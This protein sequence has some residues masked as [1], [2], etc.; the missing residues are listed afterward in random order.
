MDNEN[1]VRLLAAADYLQLDDAKQLCVKQLQDVVGFD[2]C[3]TILGAA[4][5][6]ECD[7]IKTK[8]L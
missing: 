6:Y 5:T 2:N 4:I 8:F 3:F 1:V 7:A